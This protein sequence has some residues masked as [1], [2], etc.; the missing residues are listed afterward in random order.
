M[1]KLRLIYFILIIILCIPST[2][3]AYL[4]PGTGNILVYIVISLAGA[5]IFSIKG[6]FY[7]L[8]GKKGITSKS[9]KNGNFDHIVLFNEGK[10]Y[11]STFKPI[12]DALIK[13]K[14]PFSYYTMDIE[15]P[16]LTI[17]YENEYM[18]K[19]YIGTG[20]IAY[21]K[22][23]KLDAYV[24]LSTTPN[25]GTDGF[26]LPRSPKIK[27][28]SHVFHAVSD[29]CF[30][31]KG[32]LDHYDSVMLVGEFEIPIIRKL[33]SL[34]GLPEKH[35]Y[36]AGLPYLDVLASKVP[37]NLATNGRT[38]LIAPSW[39][40]KGCL[41]LYGHKF[42]QDLAQAGYNIIVRP[43]PQ[44]WKVETEMLSKIRSVMSK[45]QNVIWDVD[46]DGTQ[47]L[48]KSDIMISD[49]SSV[50][51]DYIFLYK[52]PVITLE[53][54]MPDPEDFEMADLKESILEKI[55]SEVGVTLNHETIDNI[56][57][58]VRGI[59]D[60]NS[61]AYDLDEFRDKTIYNFG[62][63]GEVIAEYLVSKS[64]ELQEA[65]EVA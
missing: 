55:I 23:G 22:M 36:P 8:I 52:K 58:V 39:G 26:P 5:L 44:S 24:V 25:I 50:R 6:L 19:R 62:Y 40:T 15:D 37:K 14:Q 63:S 60:K 4:D 38:I 33:E 41:K 43:H 57:A 17:E 2:A 35:L 30:Y 61:L 10:N 3:F 11:W 18:N 31:H 46:P 53:S 48:A 21:A 34:R 1:D 27:H 56:V 65:K 13:L 29:L 64:H 47:S 32:S 42:I 49:T 20:N 7:A 54:P 51:F 16:G 12:V 28:L 45:Y 59:L 9:D